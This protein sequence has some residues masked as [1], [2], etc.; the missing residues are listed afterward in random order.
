MRKYPYYKGNDCRVLQILQEKGIG[1]CKCAYDQYAHAL[2]YF[3]GL[4]HGVVGMPDEHNIIECNTIVKFIEE[5]SK[6]NV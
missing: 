5:I 4:V 6:Y 2:V 1:V 3:D